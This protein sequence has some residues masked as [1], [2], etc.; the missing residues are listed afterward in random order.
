[1]KVN[2]DANATTI[3]GIPYADEAKQPI[4]WAKLVRQ[5]VG[6]RYQGEENL[7]L[8][9]V[10]QR[11]TLLKMLAKGGEIELKAEQAAMIKDCV[12]RGLGIDAAVQIFDMI[13]GV[14]E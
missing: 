13:D 8:D 9:Q 6:A 3:D 5:A 2:F 4:S 11:G 12:R 1:M 10:M 14:K 7:S